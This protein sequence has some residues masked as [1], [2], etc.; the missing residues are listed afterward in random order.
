M[1]AS[2]NKV[3]DR[4]N[5]CLFL[6]L[7]GNKYSLETRPK[8]KGLDVREELLKFHSSNYS[9][10]LMALTVIGKGEAGSVTIYSVLCEVTMFCM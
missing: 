4:Y 9:S 2:F 1:Y 5:L 6:C 7:S 8:E 10:N 3:N